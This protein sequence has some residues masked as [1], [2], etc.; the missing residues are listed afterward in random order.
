MNVVFTT[1]DFGDEAA[2][3]EAA[4]EGRP[5]S[6]E[7]HLYGQVV[8]THPGQDK[9]EIYDDLPFLVQSLCAEAPETLRRSGLAEVRLVDWPNTLT[10]RREGDSILLNGEAGEAA[11]YPAEELL[12]ALR[13]CARRFAAFLDR[14][15]QTAPQFQ[16][17]SEWLQAAL[18]NGSSVA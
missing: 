18:A 11:R 14:V 4:R 15:A 2:S 7:Y 10:L 6:E 9:L 8:I 5:L 16:K 1:S 17:R 3:D 12:T 13:D